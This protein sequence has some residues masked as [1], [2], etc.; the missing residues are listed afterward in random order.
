MEEMV[1]FTI[2]GEKKEYKKG[3]PFSV[4]AEEYQKDYQDDIVLVSLNNR[5]CE[6]QKCAKRD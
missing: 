5:L 6:L 2:H 1:C 4:I 3:T